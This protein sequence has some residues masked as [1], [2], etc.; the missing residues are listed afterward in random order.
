LGH[1]NFNGS[2]FFDFFNL[3]FMI[4]FFLDENNPIKT[5]SYYYAF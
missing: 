2:H 1:N 3:L 4:D 5:N